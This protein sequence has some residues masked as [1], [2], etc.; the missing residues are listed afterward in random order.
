MGN[1]DRKQGVIWLGKYEVFLEEFMQFIDEI[2]DE[3]LLTG[4]DLSKLELDLK[5]HEA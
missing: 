4:Y 2:D 5:K 1:D 3:I